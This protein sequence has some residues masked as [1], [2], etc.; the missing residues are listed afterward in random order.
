[1]NVPVLTG[2]WVEP[3]CKDCYNKRIVS[4]KRWYEETGGD[5]DFT[6]TPY[7][8]LKKEEQEIKMVVTY[9]C[10]SPKKG[11][12]KKKCDYSDTINKIMDRQRKLFKQNE[13]N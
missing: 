1:M 6:Y 9:K 7:E 13:N 4:D 8:D 10:Y 2:G 11:D 5:A 12:Y 3:L